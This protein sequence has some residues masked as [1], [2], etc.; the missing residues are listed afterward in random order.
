MAKDK[1]SFVLYSDYMEIFEE[2]SNEDAGKLIKHLFRY[3][4]D[5]NPEAE[6][7]LI[8]ISFIPI[9]LQ[10]KRDLIHWESV[11][12]KRSEAGKISASKR[13]QVSTSVESVEQT[14][15][16]PTVTV[17]DTVND[18]VNKNKEFDLFWDKYHKISEL[19]KTDKEL[20]LK[21]WNKLTGPEKTKAFDKISDY[22]KSISEIK[23]RKKAR[24]YLS[25]KA[26]ND[27]FSSEKKFT[28]N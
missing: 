25:D 21:H 12:K 28:F 5:K 27:E 16:N 3:V 23:Y 17:N 8:K 26:F 2:L 19:T 13:Q 1:K 15:T 7:Q 11:R 9:K 18:T 10:L 24:T 22:C 20:T 6:N 14:P 4:N